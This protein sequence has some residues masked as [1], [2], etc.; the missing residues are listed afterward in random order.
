MDAGDRESRYGNRMDY[1]S[2]S[3]NRWA[4]DYFKHGHTKINTDKICSVS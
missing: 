4:G 2:V 3:N 1:M